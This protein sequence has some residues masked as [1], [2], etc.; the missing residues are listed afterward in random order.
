MKINYQQQH[1]FDALITVS[2]FFLI[3]DFFDNFKQM[4]IF[5]QLFQFIVV[6][7][8]ILQAAT[9][10]YCVLYGYGKLCILFTDP[11]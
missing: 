2:V 7:S 8:Y 10:F 6:G 3:I 4:F 9:V 1:V 5:Y 11:M